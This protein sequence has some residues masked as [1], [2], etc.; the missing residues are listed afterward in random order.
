MSQKEA[1]VATIV[2][3]PV[4]IQPTSWATKFGSNQLC[5]RTR[6]DMT[7]TDLEIRPCR[8]E[9]EKVPFQVPLA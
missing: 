9:R 4:I 2:K 5:E 7:T 6:V 8:V 3:K 1:T